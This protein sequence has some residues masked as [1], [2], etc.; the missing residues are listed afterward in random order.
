[1]DRVTETLLNDFAEEH[2]FAR[3]QKELFELFASYLTVHRHHAETFDP[4]EIVTGGGGDTGIDAIAI[5][6]NGALIT[7]LEALQEHIQRRRTWM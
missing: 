3:T 4:S 6:V 5:I 1:M 7:D 2:N